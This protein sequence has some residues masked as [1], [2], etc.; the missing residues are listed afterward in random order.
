MTSE[1][2]QVALDVLADVLESRQRELHASEVLEA[3]RSAGATLPS[4]ASAYLICNLALADTRFRW[5]RGQL[6]GLKE[7]GTVRRMSMSRAAREVTQT[8]TGPTPFEEIWRRV[9]ERIER[10]IPRL[11]LSAYL[12][13]SN[14]AYDEETGLWA[15]RRGAQARTAGLEGDDGESDAALVSEG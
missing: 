13:G 4:T 8:V 14:L 1:A 6:L 2:Q 15:P 10:Q 3:L 5:S 7:W 12:Q 11:Q 9:C